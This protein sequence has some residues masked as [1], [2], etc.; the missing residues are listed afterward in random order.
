MTRAFMDL[1]LD[2][3]I[4]G[5]PCNSSPRF[6]NTITTS[7]SGGESVNRN[8]LHPLHT[9]TLPNAIREH[10]QFEAIHDHWLLSGGREFVWPFR[11][12]LDF[13]SCPLVLPNVIPDFDGEDQA[14]GVGD[15]L[16]RDFQLQKVYSR[17]GYTYTRPIE[18]PV[19]SALVILVNGVLP[20]D[21]GGGIGGPYTYTVSRPGGVVTFTPALA[22][23]VVATWGGLFDVLVRFERDDSFDGIVQSY[24]VSGFSDLTFQEVRNC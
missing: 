11:D 9:F 5:F 12:P 8:W 10:P 17:G 1:Y 3:Q 18:L 21:A 15:G 23:N 6:N 20:G 24:R 13:A 7:A 16:Q 14:L 2:A 22:S 19:V 4:P